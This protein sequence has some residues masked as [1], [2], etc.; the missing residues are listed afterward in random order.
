M[1][2]DIQG[3]KRINSNFETLETRDVSSSTTSSLKFPLILT[4]YLNIY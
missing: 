2:T 1:D 3:P 4:K